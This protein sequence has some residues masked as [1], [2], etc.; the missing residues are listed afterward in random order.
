VWRAPESD[1]P[2]WGMWRYRAMLPVP[3]NASPVTLAE[4]GTPLLPGPEPGVWVK[5]EYQNPTGSHKD[6]AASLVFTWLQARG[7]RR[8]VE[9]SSGNAGAAWAAYA[10]R[11]GIEAHI[12]VPASASG[13]K[14]AHIAALGA[15]LHP[16]PGPRRAAR[17]AAEDAARQGLGVYASHA[18]LPM[19]L[20]G[21]ATIAYEI[22][23]A[24][25]DAPGSVFVPV[26]HGALLVG[27]MRGFEALQRA[28]VVTARPRLVG[29]QALA[30]APL[31][32]MSQGGYEA[33]LL[34]S[35][36]AETAAEG[37]RVKD[38]VWG[39]AVVQAIHA[40][41]GAIAAVDEDALRAARDFLARHGFYIEPTAA[42]VWAAYERLRDWAP[43]PAVLVLTGSGHKTPAP[44]PAEP[45][46]QTPAPDPSTR[47]SWW[48]RI[49]LRKE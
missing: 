39:Q 5:A 38:P 9:D 11:A 35:D 7:V 25:G 30:C 8:V 47:R 4:G 42:L 45:V 26:G 37:V 17:D 23:E 44:A 22:V 16:V 48:Q 31:W 43:R 29:V 40:S 15:R 2:R 34:V 10:A 33:W 41:Q 36:E 49:F 1:A 32:A 6:R 18:W 21:Y 27:L 3:H 14:R 19:V 24:L 46:P 12:F 13:P 28:A 20:D